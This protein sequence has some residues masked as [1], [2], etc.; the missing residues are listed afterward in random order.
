MRQRSEMTRESSGEAVKDIRRAIKKRYSADGHLGEICIAD[1]RSSPTSP[2][3]R[4]IQRACRLKTVVQLLESRVEMIVLEIHNDRL[5]GTWPADRQP[6]RV[7][8]G[9]R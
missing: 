7:E 6:D 8:V 4:I 1:S 3:R 9:T 2:Y 5:R